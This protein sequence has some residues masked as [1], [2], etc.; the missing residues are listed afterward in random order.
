MGICENKTKV[1][2][3]GFQRKLASAFE[4]I[5]S[6]IFYKIGLKQQEIQANL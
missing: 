5:V 2:G 6:W 4:K 3:N 1:M